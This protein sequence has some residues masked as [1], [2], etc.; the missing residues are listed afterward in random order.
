MG[1]QSH[2]ITE[3]EHPNQNVIILLSEMKKGFSGPLGTLGKQV[4]SPT[5]A[6]AGFLKIGLPLNWKAAVGFTK[7]GTVIF[8]DLVSKSRL[9]RPGWQVIKQEELEK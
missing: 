2:T 7:W 5:K 9:A 8:S 3:L 4:G 6:R 1:V